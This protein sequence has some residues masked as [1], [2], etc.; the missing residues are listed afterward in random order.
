MWIFRPFSQV[1]LQPRDTTLFWSSTAECF[2][3]PDNF[4][5]L[6][7]WVFKLNIYFWIVSVFTT[8]PLIKAVWTVF[9]S[10]TERNTHPI[11]RA[12]ELTWTSFKTHKHTQTRHTFNSTIPSC[13]FAFSSKQSSKQSSKPNVFSNCPGFMAYDQTGWRHC[14]ASG[15]L[16]LW[17]TPLMSWQQWL[18]W[19]AWRGVRC[20][21]AGSWLHTAWGKERDLKFTW[22][23]PIL[24][25][26]AITT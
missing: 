21:A 15:G 17:L 23:P 1:L 20:T 19:K 16:V 14:S 11:Y 9:D 26:K 7:T 5:F 4:L 2:N 13:I 6:R 22:K 8:V 24:F 12:Q 3:P 18:S 25:Q 10:I